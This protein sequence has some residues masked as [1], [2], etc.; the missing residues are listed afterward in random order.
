MLYRVRNDV[1]NTS[2]SCGVSEFEQTWASFYDAANLRETYRF[3]GSGARQQPSSLYSGY[4]ARSGLASDGL[5]EV[6]PPGNLTSNWSPVLSSASARED[7]DY[8]GASQVPSTSALSGLSVAT[9]PVM[10][11]LR[12]CEMVMGLRSS[13]GCLMDP[14]LAD[15]RT[16]DQCITNIEEVSTDRLGATQRIIDLELQLAR[17]EAQEY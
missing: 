13:L 17:L 15:S 9:L 2:P 3:L 7:R 14:G 6:Q 5:Q 4:S 8:S 1:H 12:V 11:E 10:M 16:L